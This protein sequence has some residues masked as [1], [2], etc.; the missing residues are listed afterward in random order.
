MED[1]ERYAHMRVRR[2]TQRNLRIAAALAGKRGLD[3]LDELV[4]Q[5]LQRLQQEGGKRHVAHQEDQA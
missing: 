2:T 4:E 5:E 1:K 3:L